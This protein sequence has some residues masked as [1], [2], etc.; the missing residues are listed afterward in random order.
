MAGRIP[1]VAGSR[2]FP[3]AAE[4]IHFA[5]EAKALGVDAIQLYPPTMGHSFVPTGQ[6]LTRFYDEVLSAVDMPVILSSNLTTGFEVPSATFD[7]PVD[8][9]PHVI[10]IFKHHSDQHNV[11]EFVARFSARTTVL[12]MSQR[13]M[14]SYAVGARGELDHLQN[15]APRLCRSLH[16]A[17]FRDDFEAANSSYLRIV[18]LWSAIIAFSGEFS[19]PRVAVYKAVLRILGIGAGFTRPPYLE[20]GDDAM[21][22]LRATIDRL[23]L[24]QSEGLS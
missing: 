5:R 6:M 9:F 17:I 15:I 14:F 19:V 12:T 7:R 8:E 23:S 21:A 4:N 1:V 22:A 10:G 11:A 3:T 13:L 18:E 2:E 24:R 16:D 20:T